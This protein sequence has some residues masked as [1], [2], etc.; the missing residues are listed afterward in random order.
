MYQSLLLFLA[1]E[2]APQ[3]TLNS[4]PAV[5]RPAK[6]L[7]GRRVDPGFLAAVLGNALGF[8]AILAG[9]WF[10]VQLMQALLPF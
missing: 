6:P 1:P 10:S 3:A 5:D 9:C 2:N 4:P 8:G 7:L